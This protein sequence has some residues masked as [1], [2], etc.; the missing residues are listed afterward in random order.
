MGPALPNILNFFFTRE[1]RNPDFYM[2]SIFKYWQRI[3]FLNTE[4][5][6]GAEQTCHWGN[7]VGSWVASLWLWI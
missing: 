1:A 6:E 2:K 5:A 7:L 3:I 4:Q